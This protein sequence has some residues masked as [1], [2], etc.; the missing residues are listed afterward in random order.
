MSPK[1]KK[2]SVPLPPSSKENSPPEI[3]VLT[4]V[5]SIPLI[6]SSLETI[7]GA[8]LNNSYTRTSYSTA[9][10]LSNSAY[11]LSEPLQIRLAPFI[12]HAN[13]Y[14]N[15][16]VD[17]VESR[18]PYPFKAK[19]EEVASLVRERKQSA[20]DY[21]NKTLDDKVL[22]PAYT[23]AQEIDQVCFVLISQIVQ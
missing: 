13:G 9:K 4:R 22:T 12:I 10:G 5:A 17:V 19:P 3:T 2:S 7:N 20:T 14:A 11:K 23:A 18:Y 8:L 1:T 16:A 15:K 6:S 21:A